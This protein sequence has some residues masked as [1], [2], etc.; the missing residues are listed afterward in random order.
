VGIVILEIFDL[1]GTCFG[2]NEENG[3]IILNYVTLFCLK[4]QK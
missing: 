3:S 1:V 2:P 4:M